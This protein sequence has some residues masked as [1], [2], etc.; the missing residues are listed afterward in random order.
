MSCKKGDIEIGRRA[1]E[2]LREM[3]PE[4]SNEAIAKRLH[5]DRNVIWLW[6][7][8]VTPSSIALQRMAIAGCDVKYI[9]T[10]LRSDK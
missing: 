10:G 2:E 4:L 6:M 7:D 3:F 8:G 1:V 9:L 5:M